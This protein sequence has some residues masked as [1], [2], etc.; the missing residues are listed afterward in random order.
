MVEQ[1]G[2]TKTT[3]IEF[4]VVTDELYCVEDIIMNFLEDLE[5]KGHIVRYQGY[6]SQSFRVISP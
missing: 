4:E 3:A 1:R 5:H 2:L 6:A